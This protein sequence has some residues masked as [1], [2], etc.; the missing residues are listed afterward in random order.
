MVLSAL[1][2][3]QLQPFIH[4]NG[5][6]DKYWTTNAALWTESVSANSRGMWKQRRMNDVIRE[7][8]L[9]LSFCEMLRIFCSFQWCGISLYSCLP[10]KLKD[11]KILISSWNI[12]NF[13]FLFRDSIKSASENLHNLFPFVNP[14]NQTCKNVN[15]FPND[16]GKQNRHWERHNRIQN[17]S[18]YENEMLAN[19]C[20]MHST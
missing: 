6:N 18:R 5:T 16:Y 7:A 13:V 2:C 17:V 14:C 4:S 12:Y 15:K 8:N 10:A 1:V 3:T 19:I 11:N 9:N 20:K